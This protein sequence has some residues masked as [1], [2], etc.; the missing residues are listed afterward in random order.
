VVGNTYLEGTYSEIYPHISEDEAGLRRL[1]MQFSFPG[2]IPSHASPECPGSIHEGGELGYS[3]SHAIGAAFD[4][5]DLVVTGVKR[6]NTNVTHPV[7]PSGVTASPLDG[8]RRGGP[9]LLRGVWMNYC[10]DRP[11]SVGC[12]AG[13]VYKGHL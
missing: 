10:H 13:A 6:K 8:S 1:F 12:T 5:P 2:G 11:S 7:G 4:N 3:L 9:V